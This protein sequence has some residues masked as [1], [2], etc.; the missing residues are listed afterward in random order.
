MIIFFV[1]K[2]LLPGFLTLD[3]WL[4]NNKPKMIKIQTRGVSQQHNISISIDY[5]FFDK[6]AKR[7]S[8]PEL[9]EYCRKA[10]EFAVGGG[11]QHG[12]LTKGK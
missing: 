3:I 10:I 4:Q 9:I 11:Q 8:E 2:L 12:R 1:V 5:R 7:V 6:L